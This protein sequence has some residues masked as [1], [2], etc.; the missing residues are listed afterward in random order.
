MSLESLGISQGIMTW[1]FISLAFILLLLIAF[2]FVGI[3]E[4]DLGGVMRAKINSF[5]PIGK[6]YN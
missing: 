6:N 5:I 1:G 2:I 3:Q 4:F